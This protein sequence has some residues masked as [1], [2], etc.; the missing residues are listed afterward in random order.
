MR[1]TEFEQKITLQR[2]NTEKQ[3][4]KQQQRKAAERQALMQVMYGDTGRQLAGIELA[5]AEVELQQQYAE[6]RKAEAEAGEADAERVTALS[7]AEV[8]NGAAIR[9][10]AAAERKRRQR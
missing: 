2:L 6:L 7:Q 4:L 5:K 9:R 10:M 3:K 8:Q 1:L